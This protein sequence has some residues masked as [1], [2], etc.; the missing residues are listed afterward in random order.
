[1]PC[2]TS[3]PLNLELIAQT[4]TRC[5]FRHDTLIDAVTACEAN[6]SC[7]G[8]TRDEGLR[9]GP[10]N[11]KM[12]YE[13]RSGR[14]LQGVHPPSS[15][16]FHRRRSPSAV[17]LRQPSD[18]RTNESPRERWRRQYM[19]RH[20]P[21][22]VRPADHTFLQNVS[23]LRLTLLISGTLRGFHR[24][25][26]T[27][28]NVLAKPNMPEVS[29]VLSTY[30]KNDC[31][32]SSG[33]G[34]GMNA[35][36]VHIDEAKS[37]FS[38]K[39]LSVV[40][41]NQSTKRI[42]DLFVDYRRRPYSIFAPT[43]AQGSVIRYTSQFYLRHRAWGM[44]PAKSDI[45]VLTRPD[46]LMYGKWVARRIVGSVFHV[47]LLITLRDGSSCQVRL[48]HNDILLPYS[49]IHRGEWDDTFAI[50]LRSSMEKYVRLYTRL[51][52]RTYTGSFPHP[53]ALLKYHLQKEGLNIVDA[54][55]AARGDILELVK[56]CIK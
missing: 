18:V 49:D 56:E 48:R 19:V 36:D 53:E 54:C 45:V 35:R 6:R 17:C 12:P 50:G 30:S 29:L 4:S 47:V 34:L 24:C 43:V 9:C 22:H 44:S 2:W 1:M 7:G 37:A 46:A 51:I 20:M 10:Y 52:Q 55:G 27:I 21:Q 3:Y 38:L 41:S 39:G 13:L 42:Q 8:I 28:V 33:H 32:G 11:L 31:G 16:L 5:N 25:A 14:K 23:M 40:V 15:W 26:P